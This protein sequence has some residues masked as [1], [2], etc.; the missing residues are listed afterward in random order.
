[1]SISPQIIVSLL[2]YI[3]IN[4]YYRYKILI[5]SFSKQ[6]SSPFVSSK[7]HAGKTASPIEGENP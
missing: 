7:T 5:K 3:D 6:E 4:I 2:F 1:M